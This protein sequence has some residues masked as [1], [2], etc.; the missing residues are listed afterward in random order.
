MGHFVKQHLLDIIPP[1]A[2]DDLPAQRN[3]SLG[4]APAAQSGRHVPNGEKGA[5]DGSSKGFGQQPKGVFPFGQKTA[6]DL[7]IEG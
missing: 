2:A 5:F 3:F 4:P 1:M 7:A 6:Q